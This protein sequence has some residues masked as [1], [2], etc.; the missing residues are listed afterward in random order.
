MYM[1]LVLSLTFCPKFWENYYDYIAQLKHS[2]ILTLVTPVIK[3]C[4]KCYNYDDILN[5]GLCLT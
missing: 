2:K 4:L 3:D 1:P 5:P